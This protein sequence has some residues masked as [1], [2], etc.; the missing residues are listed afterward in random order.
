MN[1]IR[2]FSG[3][4]QFF[5]GTQG[6]AS[7]PDM[8]SSGV[9]ENI[10]LCKT[11]IFDGVCGMFFHNIPHTPPDEAMS[12]GLVKACVPGKNCSVTEKI[13]FL[14]EYQTE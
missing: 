2:I 11:P 3:T 1:S 6:F 5:P 14:I 7:P 4:E 8:A 12:G 9:L 13:E 10:I